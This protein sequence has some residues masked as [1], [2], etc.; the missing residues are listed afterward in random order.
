VGLQV[1][2]R[3]QTTALI[4]AKITGHTCQLQQ[5]TSQNTSNSG[6]INGLAA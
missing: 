4:R 3:Y 6:T 1:K 5:C 2:S